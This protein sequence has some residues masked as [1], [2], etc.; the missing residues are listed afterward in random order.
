[1]QYCS[2]EL[3]EKYLLP[4]IE[5]MSDN[6]ANPSWSH[7]QGFEPY[8]L[9]KMKRIVL[10]RLYYNKKNEPD[11]DANENIQAKRSAFYEY[12]SEMDRRRGTDFL[13]VFP[14]M[15]E[16]WN[17]CADTREQYV[18]RSIVEEK[19]IISQADIMSKLFGK[20]AVDNAQAAK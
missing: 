2:H 1:M 6:T 20:P 12:V 17:L 13:S 11:R 7:H 9:E 10:H 19:G 8:E 3:V 18:K 16:Y 4:C 14:E 5:Y 15:T